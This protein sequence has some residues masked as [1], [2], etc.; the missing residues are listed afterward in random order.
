MLQV[1]YLDV[2]KLDR[3]LHMLQYARKARGRE[4]SHAWSDGAFP[5]WVCEMQA[6]AGACCHGR[7]RGVQVRMGD[8]VLTIVRALVLLFDFFLRSE[9]I[10][11]KRC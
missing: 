8:G 5:A 10:R 1:F 4:R 2:V 9:Q 3:V 6:W 11:R 7:G